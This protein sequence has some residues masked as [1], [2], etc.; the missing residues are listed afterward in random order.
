MVE[1]NAGVL[2]IA[3]RAFVMEKG[4]MVYEGS[5]DEILDHSEIR[6]AYLGTPA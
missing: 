1:Q 4:T 6:Q 5:G 3:D 2:K